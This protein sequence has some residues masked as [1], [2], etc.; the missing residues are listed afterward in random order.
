M[1]DHNFEKVAI[2]AVKEYLISLL[3]EEKWCDAR[4]V[5]K[6]LEILVNSRGMAEMAPRLREVEKMPSCPEG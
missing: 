2:T 3:G 4:Q 1:E 6:A 5:G